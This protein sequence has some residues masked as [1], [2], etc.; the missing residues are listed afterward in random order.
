MAKK[1]RVRFE[2]R[3]PGKKIAPIPQNVDSVEIKE[4]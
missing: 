2:R 1:K 3:N 4:S